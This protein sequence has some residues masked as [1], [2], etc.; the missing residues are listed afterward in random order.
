MSDQPYVWPSLEGA[1]RGQL[2]SP[3]HNAVAQGSLNDDRLYLLLASIDIIRVREVK[4]AQETLRKLYYENHHQNRTRIKVVYDELAELA[5][6]VIFIGG[7]T[8]SGRMD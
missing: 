6:D 7:A 8:V 1:T 3:L 4:M 5:A 2:I